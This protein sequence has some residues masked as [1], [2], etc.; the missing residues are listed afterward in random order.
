MGAESSRD[1][2][3]GGVA[4]RADVVVADAVAALRAL[5][6]LNAARRR[7][8]VAVRGAAG[9]EEA[10]LLPLVCSAGCYVLR[11]E[12][13][14]N[15]M[16]DAGVMCAPLLVYAVL[17]APTPALTPATA[18]WFYRPTADLQLLADVVTI[19]K[20]VSAN[21][22]GLSNCVGDDAG[23]PSPPKGAV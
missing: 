4:Q 21:A 5:A 9:E 1:Q 13:S 12:R 6:F 17:R 22:K 16:L 10:T 11:G 19:P 3:G 20:G 23:T 7:I 15:L 2:H 14:R 18:P 8:A